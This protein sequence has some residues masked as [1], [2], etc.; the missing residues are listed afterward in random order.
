M[1]IHVRQLIC[2]NW[3]FQDRFS[4]SYYR[5]PSGHIIKLCLPTVTLRKL[6][7]QSL[8]CKTESSKFP[9]Q[10]QKT[11]CWQILT[12]IKTNAV[13]FQ[14]CFYSSGSYAQY[15]QVQLR[16]ETTKLSEKMKVQRYIFLTTV[17]THVYCDPISYSLIFVILGGNND[18][19]RFF[20]KL[21]PLFCQILCHIKLG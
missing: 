1:G 14:L 5:V 19:F 6:F 16:I 10:N 4:T 11:K 8:G 12:T 9:F 15:Y 3:V 18:V 7:L 21:K 20:E 13:C 17:L 2:N